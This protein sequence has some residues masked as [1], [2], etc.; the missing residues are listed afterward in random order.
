[1]LEILTAVILILIEKV[2]GS[3]TFLMVPGF[4]SL[5]YRTCYAKQVHLNFIGTVPM[6]QTGAFTCEVANDVNNTMNHTA[7]ITIGECNS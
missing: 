6:S 1:M 7:T 3:G 5:L 2:E 4:S